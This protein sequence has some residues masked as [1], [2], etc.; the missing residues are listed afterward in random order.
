MNKPKN[1]EKEIREIKTL[2]ASVPDLV[3]I[4]GKRQDITTGKLIY[5]LCKAS[6]RLNRLTWVLIVLTSVLILATIADIV[7]RAIQG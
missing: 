4:D 3:D 6:K 2:L 1:S 5:I 7:M